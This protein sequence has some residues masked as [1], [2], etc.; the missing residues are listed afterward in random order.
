MYSKTLLP[1]EQVCLYGSSPLFPSLFKMAYHSVK[2]ASPLTS[3]PKLTYPQVEE[4]TIH[5]FCRAQQHK[6]IEHYQYNFCMTFL[7]E[8]MKVLRILRLI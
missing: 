8:V 2:L 1:V 4:G 5:W 3:I 7:C 6:T